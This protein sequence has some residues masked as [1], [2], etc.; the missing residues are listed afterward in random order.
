MK[1]SEF[2]VTIS[3]D[4]YGKYSVHIVTFEDG[5]ET[6]RREMTRSRARSSALKEAHDALDLIHQQL[7]KGHFQLVVAERPNLGN[8][9]LP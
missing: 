6:G 2:S 5:K 3:A 4:R 1:G 8:G 9:E 7:S